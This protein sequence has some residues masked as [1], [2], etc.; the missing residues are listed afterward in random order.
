M[1]NG[2]FLKSVVLANGTK[3]VIK[4]KWQETQQIPIVI[5]VKEN[6]TMLTGFCSRES[7]EKKKEDIDID[8]ETIK[9]SLTSEKDQPGV[10][11]EVDEKKMKFIVSHQESSDSQSRFREIYVRMD[12]KKIEGIDVIPMTMEIVEEMTELMKLKSKVNQQE[13][14]L[15]KL[16]KLYE[17]LEEEKL[18]TILEQETKV[19]SLLNSKKQHISQLERKMN[20]KFK[21]VFNT[22]NKFNLSSDFD[23]S[24]MS[25]HE[26]K[27]SRSTP[28]RVMYS[29]Q[30]S[31]QE[32]QPSTSK[33]A[34]NSP[35][36]KKPSSRNNTPKS[37][38]TTPKSTTRSQ[39]Q[40]TPKKLKPKELFQFEQLNSEDE[41]FKMKPTKSEK[42]QAKITRTDESILE[43]KRLNSSSSEASSRTPDFL[44]PA[45]TIE[46]GDDFSKAT[47]R[48]RTVKEKITVD[49]EKPEQLCEKENDDNYTQ[50][51]TPD[52]D[53][54]V[55]QSS[56][57]AYSPSV[58]EP[59]SK[60]AAAKSPTK[61]S[62][63]TKK[64]S[65]W[66]VDTQDFDMSP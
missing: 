29:S 49:P 2:V 62:Q 46:S 26:P 4:S 43:G 25:V 37:I 45:Q 16:L 40:W 54:F 48:A 59:Y 5:F 55:V 50:N 32:P 44:Q 19:V 58:F 27:S 36:R 17:S 33:A 6:S 60:R 51:L 21:S 13:D 56:Q 63:R 41:T 61:A 22:S 34:Y 8:Y 64:K 20:K 7:L 65:V 35:A 11:Y 30:E 38:K 24:D 52:I 14:D 10:S 1:E 9:A 57:T 66:S 31:S 3:A 18:K 47:K 39:R 12:V 53:D 28:S 23:Q 15:Q 42:S